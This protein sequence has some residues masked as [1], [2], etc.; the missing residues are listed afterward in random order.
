METEQEEL[1]AKYE[2]NLGINLS[3][4]SSTTNSKD[5]MFKTRK[6]KETKN[7]TVAPESET[8]KSSEEARYLQGQEGHQ[9]E[10]DKGDLESKIR[11]KQ[12]KVSAYYL[13]TALVTSV[14]V[15]MAGEEMRTELLCE[16]SG[17]ESASRVLS[18]DRSANRVICA[19]RLATQTA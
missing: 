11:E 7:N 18:S 2:K 9:I 16:T 5:S 1:E 13:V 14:R 4:K 8:T 3:D 19:A 12:W 17:F 6:Q 10:E 15:S